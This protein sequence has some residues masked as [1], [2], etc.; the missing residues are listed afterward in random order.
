[1]RDHEEFINLGKNVCDNDNRKKI[2][3]S[4]GTILLEISE[5]CLLRT[6][7]HNVDYLWLLLKMSCFQI[8]Q[9]IDCLD[10]ISV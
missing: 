5:C 4:L 10:G 1:M 8:L 7:C 6:F 9:R 3:V 2:A